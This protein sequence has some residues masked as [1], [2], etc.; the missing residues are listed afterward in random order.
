MT[1]GT[2]FALFCVVTLLG[3]GVHPEKEAQSYLEQNK[4]D[5]GKPENMIDKGDVWVFQYSTP[6]NT[7]GDHQL[8]INKKSGQI[9]QGVSR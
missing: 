5:W 1:K 6:P 9:S 2:L 8:I 3:C 7:L 4:L